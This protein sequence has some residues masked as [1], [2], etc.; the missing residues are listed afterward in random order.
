MVSKN[1]FDEALSL[2]KSNSQADSIKRDIILIAKGNYLFESGSY[3]KAA[4]ILANTSES[5][6][7][8]ALKFM[9]IQKNSSLRLYLITK[10]RTLP[11]K[12]YMQR[13]MLSSWIVES[14]TEGLN[15]LDNNLFIKTNSTNNTLN[16]NGDGSLDTSVQKKKDQFLKKFHK[17]LDEFKDLLDKETVYQII[18]AHDRPDELLADL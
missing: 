5:F 14:F 12:F 2:L 3:D 1:M 4:T 10:L 17:F 18:S 15:D 8:V 7:K 6:E 16:A 11:S 13:V 9:N